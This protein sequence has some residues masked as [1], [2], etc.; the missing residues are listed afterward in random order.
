MYNIDLTAEAIEDLASFRKFD[1]VRIVTEMEAQ[2]AHDPAGETRNRKRLRPNKLAEW[3]LR[4]DNFC[5]FYDVV[6]ADLAVRVIAI[7][8]KK[9]S[10]LF[11]QGDRYEL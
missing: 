8:E 5:I 6:P 1:Q 10:D 3:A 11:I 2:L 4:V 7:G 9:G